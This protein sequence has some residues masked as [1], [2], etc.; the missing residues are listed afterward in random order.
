MGIKR[1]LDI[2][3]LSLCTDDGFGDAP[4][5]HRKRMK[6]MCT[7]V[8]N[9]SSIATWSVSMTQVSIPCAVPVMAFP[10][11]VTPSHHGLAPHDDSAVQ[12]SQ[13]TLEIASHNHVL[14]PVS[15]P[16]HTDTDLKALSK[17]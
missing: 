17:R 8:P 6:S 9:M 16:E 13:Q 12:E 1:D 11:D 7:D 10:F 15:K 4:G 3:D 14:V 5:A 2:A